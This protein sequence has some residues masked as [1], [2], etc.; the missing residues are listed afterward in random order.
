MRPMSIATLMWRGRPSPGREEFDH[1]TERLEAEFESWPC[2]S[3]PLNPFNSES[4]S[5]TPASDCFLQERFVSVHSYGTGRNEP[6]LSEEVPECDFATVCEVGVAMVKGACTPSSADHDG[7]P[8]HHI[9]VPRAR[10]V[11]LFGPGHR[12]VASRTADG[13]LRRAK[14]IVESSQGLAQ[15]ASMTTGEDVFAQGLLYSSCHHVG[16]RSPRRRPELGSLQETQVVGW[17]PVAPGSGTEDLCGWPPSHA[18][19]RGG[20]A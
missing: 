6:D 10:Q 9:G 20:S 18:Q 3:N 17:A 16:S 5:P 11:E 4:T 15:Q 19:H 1:P 14:K 13:A 7:A 8:N 2:V 12:S